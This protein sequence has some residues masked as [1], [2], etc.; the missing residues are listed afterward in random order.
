[1]AYG[2]NFF[3]AVVHHT[4]Q[5]PTNVLRDTVYNNIDAIRAAQ[6]DVLAELNKTLEAAGAKIVHTEE[7]ED[8]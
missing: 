4:G 8:D 7:V 2:D 1:M 5:K 6:E 3:G